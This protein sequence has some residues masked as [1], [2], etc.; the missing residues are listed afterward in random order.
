ML[1]AARL[2]FVC[3]AKVADALVLLAVSAAN[4]VFV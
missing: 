4:V 2:P 1:P 3:P